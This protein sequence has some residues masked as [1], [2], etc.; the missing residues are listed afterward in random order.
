MRAVQPW[1]K[2][3]AWSFAADVAGGKDEVAPEG[4]TVERVDL[5]SQKPVIP[6]PMAGA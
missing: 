3:M 6:S 2:F 1:K 5:N 4:W